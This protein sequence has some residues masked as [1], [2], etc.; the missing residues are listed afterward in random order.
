MK[1]RQQGLIF[2]LFNYSPKD[3]R[4]ITTGILFSLVAVVTSTLC[5]KILTDI[6]D[7]I[8]DMIGRGDLHITDSLVLSMCLL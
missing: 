8:G 4:A 6:V 5:P 2:R 7:E 3:R 1:L